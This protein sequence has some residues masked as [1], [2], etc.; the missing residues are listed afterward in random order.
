MRTQNPNK[1][2]HVV[3][4][5]ANYLVEHTSPCLDERHVTSLVRL[6]AR[7][8]VYWNL[9]DCLS[10]APDAHISPK[11]IKANALVAAVEQDDL[12]LVTEF[13]SENMRSTISTQ[14]F[15]DVLATAASF[16]QH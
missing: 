5:T 16:S 9:A 4:L 3:R 12:Q 7:S 1:L 14:Y 10:V 15:G 2:C 8:V 13:L 6:A 11:E